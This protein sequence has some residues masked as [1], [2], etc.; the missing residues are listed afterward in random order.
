MTRPIWPPSLPQYVQEGGYNEKLPDQKIESTMDSGP[1]KNRRRFSTNWRP[2]A[3]SIKMTPEQAVVFEY[4][5]ETTLLGGTLAFDWVHPRTR[6]A[7]VMQFRKP[8]P[9]VRPEG[10]AAVYNVTV[11]QIQ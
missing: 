8:S 6:V 3:F 2:F 10:D 5:Y 11:D 1:P 9:S 4:F 7:A